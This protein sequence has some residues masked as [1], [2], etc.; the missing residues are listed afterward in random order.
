MKKTPYLTYSLRSVYKK[1]SPSISSLVCFK[2]S[3][4]S[5]KKNELTFFSQERKDLLFKLVVILES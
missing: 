2:K 4:Y 1:H 5:K 3:I